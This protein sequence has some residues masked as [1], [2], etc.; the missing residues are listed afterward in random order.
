MSIV[1]YSITNIFQ[2]V[3]IKYYDMK[4]Y[5]VLYEINNIIVMINVTC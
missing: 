4:T 5:T 2:K 1:Y 3:F